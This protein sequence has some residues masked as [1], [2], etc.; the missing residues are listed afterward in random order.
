MMMMIIHFFF[1][2]DISVFDVEQIGHWPGL[3]KSQTT[4]GRCIHFIEDLLHVKD[5]NVKVEEEN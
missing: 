4:I 3:L 1:Y 5:T 2:F